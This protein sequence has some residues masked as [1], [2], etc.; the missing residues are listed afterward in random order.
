ME[1]NFVKKYGIIAA[2]V[3]MVGIVCGVAINSASW[4]N[5]P[6]TPSMLVK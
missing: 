6:K 4:F 2:V 3:A 1:V 5:Q